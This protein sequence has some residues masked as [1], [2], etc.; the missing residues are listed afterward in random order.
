[1]CTRECRAAAARASRTKECSHCGGSFIAHRG[2]AEEQRFC[3]RACSDQ[4]LLAVAREPYTAPL[5]PEGVFW[6]NL[7]HGY[8]A[9]ADLA[10]KDLLDRHSWMRS[11]RGY[12]V[13][14]DHP[15]TLMHRVLLP[16]S[17][18]VDHI[19]RDRLD[20]RRS[21]LRHSTRELNASNRSMNRN[22]TS[23][24]KGVSPRGSRWGA[25]TTDAGKRRWLGSF[26]TPEE[27]AM[28]YDTWME[29]KHGPGCPGL[30]LSGSAPVAKPAR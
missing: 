5:A 16:D 29:S 25:R 4:R 30:N 9:L 24:F 17:V 19:N 26:D 27:A 2:R 22:N 11:A 8:F 13:T 1:M 21:N 12:A 23:G 18:A 6:V 15:R 3:S 14:T 28:A 7:G 20:N 10:D